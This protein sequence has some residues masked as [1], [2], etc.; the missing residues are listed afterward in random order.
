MPARVGT[1]CRRGG[2]HVLDHRG[3]GRVAPKADTTCRDRGITR[4]RETEG[5]PSGSAV[6]GSTPPIRHASRVMHRFTV[7]GPTTLS[8]C[9]DR[10]VLL[11]YVDE[12]FN[13]ERYDLGALLITPGAAM[14]LVDAL[15]KLAR[16]V[17]SAHL[18]FN[19]PVEFH[20]HEVFHAKD[21]WRR[22]KPLVHA[23]VGIYRRIVELVVAYADAIFVRSFRV[24]RPKTATGA[25]S[26]R[27][28]ASWRLLL[29]DIDGHAG[30]CGGIALVI[31]DEAPRDERRRREWWVYP[32]GG[33][34][35]DHLGPGLPHLLDTAYFVPSRHSRLVQSIDCV[36]YILHR[37]WTVTTGDPRQLAAVDALSG[38]ILGSGKVT[39]SDTQA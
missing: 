8:R 3:D 30:T 2:G 18:G 13:D 33:G 37:H 35:G 38:A 34:I 12:S 21:G 6:N 20:G 7:R 24:S 22:M 17:M 39:V 28:P 16:K 1:R 15:E 36:L 23:R 19:L 27:S 10:R 26:L 31:A 11:A 9:H 5:A 32:D 25:P 4:S 29:Q 14:A